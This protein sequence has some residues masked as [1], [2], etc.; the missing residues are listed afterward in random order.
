MLS[1]LD[2][3]NHNAGIRCQL[4]TQ[5]GRHQN[6]WSLH[7]FPVQGKNRRRLDCDCVP[8]SK[9]ATIL[10]MLGLKPH[11]KGL[12]IRFLWSGLL[13][14]AFVVQP[15][16]AAIGEVH[17]LSHGSTTAHAEF[18]EA[19]K[20]DPS[21]EGGDGGGEALHVLSHLAHCCGH[22][23]SAVL[24]GAPVML[25]L[26][27]SIMPPES[28]LALALRNALDDVLRPPIQA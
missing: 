21:R 9:I 27:G 14:L 6:S 10:R 5:S 22:A 16:L 2:D 3:G 13:V 26:S 12:L 4:P 11:R 25:F 1:S 24:N 19:G 18:D 28:G 8:Q 17:E 23:S 7:G 20:A 15:A